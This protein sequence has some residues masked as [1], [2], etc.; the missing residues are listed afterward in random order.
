MHNEQFHRRMALFGAL[1]TFGMASLSVKLM[2][3][4]AAS[5][6][7]ADDLQCMADEITRE[8]KNAVPTGYT[9]EDEADAGAQANRE[10]NRSIANYIAQIRAE[11]A[12]T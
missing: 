5:P 4:L 3:R 1:M 10:F 11:T 12:R 8:M 2:K 9:I 6:G 7:F